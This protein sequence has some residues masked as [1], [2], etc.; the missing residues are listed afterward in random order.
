M[1]R[2]ELRCGAHPDVCMH[3]TSHPRICFLVI[4][5]LPVSTSKR[6]QKKSKRGVPQ[7]SEN[8]QMAPRPCCAQ[9][10]RLESVC[11]TTCINCIQSGAPVARGFSKSLRTIP[12]DSSRNSGNQVQVT[13]PNLTL[14]QIIERSRHLR[15]EFC[16]R[17]SEV[18]HDE[19]PASGTN[20]LAEG[21]TIASVASIC[22]ASI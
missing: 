14:A 6:W 17:C 18:K 11:R 19:N 7:L 16:R 8:R 2:S 12:R 10:Y 3:S 15:Q 1:C 22:S 13:L 4:C 21:S 9:N 20:G 5:G